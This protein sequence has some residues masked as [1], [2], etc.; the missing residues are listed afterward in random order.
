[1]KGKIIFIIL[2]RTSTPDLYTIKLISVNPIIKHDQRINKTNSK[3][4]LPAITN[5]TD[6]FNLIK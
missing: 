3:E 5:M 4:N 1:M 6:F 2:D